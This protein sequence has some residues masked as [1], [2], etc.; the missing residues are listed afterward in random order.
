MAC[1]PSI[2]KEAHVQLQHCLKLVGHSCNPRSQEAETGRLE[3]QGHPQ[4]YSQRVRGQPGLYKTTS[5]NKQQQQKSKA[6]KPTKKT[7]EEKEI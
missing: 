7:K 6:K 1:L 4:S 2:Y 3:V 5:Q